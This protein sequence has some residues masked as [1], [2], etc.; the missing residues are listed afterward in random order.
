MGHLA[1]EKLLKALIVRTS[2]RHAPYTHS[3][4]F[5][6]EKSEIK[7]PKMTMKRLARFMEFHFEARY[8]DEQQKF[9]IKCTKE[10][11]TKKMKEIKEVYIWLKKK[12]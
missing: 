6:D 4:P 9:Y 10:F 1:L 11:A 3:L 8:P 12:L 5:L 7:I 2:Q